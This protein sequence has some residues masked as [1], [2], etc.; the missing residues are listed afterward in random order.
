MR[1]ITYLF[2]L[3][4]VCAAQGPITLTGPAKTS[5]SVLRAKG[6]IPILVQNP[7]N[8]PIKADLEVTGSGVKLAEA[9]QEFPARSTKIVDLLKSDE[10]LAA[11]SAI[12]V[13]AKY[14]AA[15][16]PQSAAFSTI[17]VA[18]KIQVVATDSRLTIAFFPFW[19]PDTND[20]LQIPLNRAPPEGWSV[21]RLYLPG[22]NGGVELTPAVAGNMI[23]ACVRTPPPEAGT[24][25]SKTA[26]ILNGVP[27]DPVNLQLTAKHHWL[28]AV[29]TILAGVLSAFVVQ[30]YLGVVRLLKALNV[31]IAAAVAAIPED[32]GQGL[33][34]KFS[35]QEP[36]AQARTAIAQL[37]KGFVTRIGA[38]DQ[39]FKDLAREVALLEQTAAAQK[40]YQTMLQAA[41]QGS[42]AVDHAIK[43]SVMLPAGIV[44]APAEIQRQFTQHLKSREA[45]LAGVAGE[46]E[47]L[48]G[49]IGAANAFIGATELLSEIGAQ[50][51]ATSGDI[52]VIARTWIQLWQSAARDDIRTSMSAA[53]LIDL[54]VKSRSNRTAKITASR[55]PTGTSQRPAVPAL[56]PIE[57]IRRDETEILRGDLGVALFALLLALVT[58]LAT[59]YWDKAFGRPLDYANLFAWA[60]GT[61]VAA[62]LFT[63]L[64]DR[65]APVLKAITR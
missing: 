59:Y 56:P 14:D 4:A 60:A 65:L 21:A 47:A 58:G 28:L 22:P 51:G 27:L 12:T 54:I 40:S 34:V 25:S 39:S 30:R 37:K 15:G 62:D 32:G 61:K 36:A 41:V 20:C 16:V 3:S 50:A 48:A 18:D 45:D 52:A 38:D 33:Q 23:R 35:A 17:V 26:P 7:S 46:I 44:H 9:R 13:T 57:A 2:A 1:L 29:L 64:L 24:Y 42:A 8:A 63:G 43:V 10:S 19:T 31:R 49:L 11:D 55:L 5:E 53:D 6:T